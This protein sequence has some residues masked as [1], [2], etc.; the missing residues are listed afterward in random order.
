MA[1]IAPQAGPVPTDAELPS[2]GHTLPV[3]P[4]ASQSSTG[5]NCGED[6]PQSE[7]QEV[8]RWLNRIKIARDY[9]AP[10]R[11]QYAIDRKYGRGDSSM[12]VRVPI[13]ATFIDMLV[14]FIYARD[15]DI[16]VF[17]AESAGNRVEEARQ[18][19][20]ALQVVIKQL[21]RKSG[22]KRQARKWVRSALT[23][24]IGW[25]KISWQEAYASDPINKNRIRDLQDNLARIVAK[26]AQLASG[27]YNG[28]ALE[29]CRAELEQLIQ[30]AV[31]NVERV[32]YNGLGIAFLRGEDMQISL[33]VDSIVDNNSGSWNAERWFLP[34]EEAYAKFGH[35]PE[36]CLKKA[37]NW[38]PRPQVERKERQ[39]SGELAA[40]GDEMSAESADQYTRGGGKDKTIMFV[41]GWEVWDAEKNMLFDVIEGVYQY[42]NKPDIPNVTTT[43]FQPYFPLAFCE[44]DGERHPQSLTERGAPL[45]DEYNRTRSNYKTHRARIRPKLVFD[46]TAM[47]PATVKKLEGGVT[48]EMVGVKLVGAAQSKV[49]D[50]SKLIVPVQYPQI[51]MALYDTSPIRQDLELVYG[52]QE[53]LAGVTV[54]K[55]ATEADIQQAGTQAR[56]GDKRDAVETQLSEIAQFTAEC[57]CQKLSDKEVRVLAGNDALW[58]QVKSIDELEQLVRLDIQAGSSGKA[59]TAARQQAWAAILPQLEAAQDKVAQLRQSDPLAHADAIDQLVQETIERTGDRM[60]TQRFLPAPNP[61]WAAFIQ[62]LQPVEGAPGAGAAGPGPGAPPIGAPA[63]PG[64]P[65]SPQEM[66]APTALPAEMEEVDA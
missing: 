13:I 54:Q 62:S 55:T 32:L 59:N 64:V 56:S 43:R 16:E 26:Q 1:G 36:A 37:A 34:Y 15:P 10:R 53:A 12:E 47:T 24:G 52:I 41:C 61:Q 42:A 49:M 4:T 51:D 30:G 27:D 17:P 23:I 45:E 65:A 66:L 60:D 5:D 31:P 50:F 2:S 57:A 46:A 22:M 20:K 39:E 25:L 40:Y 33:D 58:I 28:D 63:L 38:T 29:A 6:V 19:G 7:R 35:I 8:T 14:S 9:D 21:W 18:L 44:V 48:A 11:R 3:D